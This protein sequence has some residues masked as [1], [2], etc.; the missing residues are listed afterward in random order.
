MGVRY[1]LDFLTVVKNGS[2]KSFLFEEIYY[3]E[4]V[5]NSSLDYKII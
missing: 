2:G 3:W 1:E 4:D 5:I